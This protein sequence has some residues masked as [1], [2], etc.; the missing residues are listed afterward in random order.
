M[1]N[2]FAINIYFLNNQYRFVNNWIG[3][4]SV[5]HRC[6]IIMEEYNYDDTLAETM[7]IEE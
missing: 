2:I 4:E 3:E 7:K 6:I 1:I 5:I